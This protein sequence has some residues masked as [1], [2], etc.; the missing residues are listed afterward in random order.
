M[1]TCY[2]ELCW[3]K[4]GYIFFL[5]CFNKYNAVTPA[6]WWCYTVM[7]SKKSGTG[8]SWTQ[9]GTDQ[10]MVLMEVSY[11]GRYIENKE[12]QLYISQVTSITKAFILPWTGPWKLKNYQHKFPPPSAGSHEDR[13]TEKLSLP[14]TH[15]LSLSHTHTHTDK[16][17]G[18]VTEPPGSVAEPAV[19]I[20]E[21]SSSSLHRS[22]PQR[23]LSVS[24]LP[25]FIRLVTTL[26]LFTA[27]LT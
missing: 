11:C 18:E 27:P 17:W 23:A 14:Q 24:G 6:V 4:E 2:Q 8:C 25:L 19:S 7:C 3:S 21:W 12:T 26:F 15:T 10:D 13:N 16:A 9:C 5:H 22:A 1:F 20:D